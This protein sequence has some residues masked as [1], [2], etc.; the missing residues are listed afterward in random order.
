[1]LRRMSPNL[2]IC[3]VCGRAAE[4]FGPGPDGRREASCPSCKSLERH[5]FLVQ[6][7]A[8]VVPDVV[9]DGVIL[10]IA[11]NQFLTR[12]L[13]RFGRVLRVD[14]HPTARW[15]D[16]AGDLTRL[17]VRSAAVD[18]LVCYHVLEHVP[19]DLAAMR[20]LARVLAPGGV[21]F[22]QV[23]IRRGTTTDEDPSASPEERTRRF[24][25][26]D[27]VRWYGDDFET[28]LADSG[29][30][31]RVLT[32][33]EVVSPWMV[34]V[35]RL[36]PGEQVWLCSRADRP[37]PAVLSELGERWPEALAGVVE[38]MATASHRSVER[39]RALKVRNTTLV[40]DRRRLRRDRDRWRARYR[41][42]SSR[43]A[44]RVALRLA[45]LGRRG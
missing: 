17:P 7:L 31:A 33:E 14:L 27:H 39:A 11:P 15:V 26:V 28:R 30:R 43:P 4:E 25:Q 35:F 38:V 8:V 1:M 37:E 32:L 24:G 42:L 22:V 40:G 34:D 23:P 12:T 3:S 2:R 21:A 36:T 6:L 44:V 10:E 19:D 20:E 18:A 13:A 5:R 41:R 9:S 29:L 45:D 16:V